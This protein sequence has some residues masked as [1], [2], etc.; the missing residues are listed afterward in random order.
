MDLDPQ[1]RFH[2]LFQVSYYKYI[3]TPRYAAEHGV[4]TPRFATYA[5]VIF[6]LSK[7]L[8]QKYDFEAGTGLTFFFFNMI[9]L[10][11]SESVS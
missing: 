11:D 9:L 6:K 5:Y 10:L 2:N 4:V 3:A 7:S 8:H 1:H